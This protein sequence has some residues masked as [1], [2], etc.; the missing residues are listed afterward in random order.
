MTEVLLMGLKCFLYPF[1]VGLAVGLSLVISVMLFI[2]LVW[3]EEQDAG[4]DEVVL[5]SALR[6]HGFVAG[7]FNTADPVTRLRVAMLASD[8]MIELT[9]SERVRMDELR[10]R[11]ANEAVTEGLRARLL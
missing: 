8:L 10:D 3:Y 9:A 7:E 6:R 11:E 1:A 2:W 4:V 5:F